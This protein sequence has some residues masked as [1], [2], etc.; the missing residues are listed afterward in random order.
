MR[1]ARRRRNMQTIGLVLF[2]IL[3]LV[4]WAVVTR[5][6]RR[7]PV[8][9]S[10]WKID[11]MIQPSAGPVWTGDKDGVL[12]V[13][14]ESGQL[15]SVQPQREGV[16]QTEPLPILAAAFPLRGQPLVAG[17]VAYA[18]CED[19][20][21]YAVQWRTGRTLWSRNTGAPMTTRPAYVRI[22]VRETASREPVRVEIG[23]ALAPGATPA[24]TAIPPATRV[25]VQSRV[26]TGK[27]AGNV[28]A[29]EAG[30]GSVQLRRPTGAPI[31]NGITT[32]RDGAG[33]P[34]ALVPL[35]SSV[36]TRGGLWCLDARTGVPVWKFPGRGQTFAAQLSPPAIE[37]TPGKPD[38][39]RVYCADDGGAVFCLDLKTGRYAKGRGWK[40]WARPLTSAPANALI[41]LRG[42]PLFK[43]YSWGRRL[44][45]GGN[46]GGVRCFDARDGNLQWTFEAGDAVRCRPRTLRWGPPNA[47]RD[48]ILIGSD[49]PAIYILDARDGSLLWKLRTEGPA[50]AGPVP[51]GNSWLTVT[52]S[53]V[54]QSFS[55]PG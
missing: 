18:P 20:T 9:S 30:T 33:R 44:V 54:L 32:T 19:G 21:L 2:L 25:K 35:L 45:V 14:T 27:H 7:S 17:N 48:L 40:S 23:S 12:L 47:E 49:G 13:P 24:A 37:V 16:T 22:E 43:Q 38:S 29:L 41:M 3:M 53:G 15:W 50:F 28:L 36:A 52:G 8:I 51:A 31:G 39:G 46:D 6:P 42:E 55:T 5:M 26:I 4:L 11:L 1:Q 34:L 10:D